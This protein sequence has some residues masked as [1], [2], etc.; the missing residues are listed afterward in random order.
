VE[1]SKDRV[2]VVISLKTCMPTTL[3]PINN[4]PVAYAWMDSLA[5]PLDPPLSTAEVGLVV[6]SMQNPANK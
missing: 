6:G 3:V 2:L 4:K 1:D 5:L